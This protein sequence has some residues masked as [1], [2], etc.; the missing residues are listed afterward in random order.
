MR[1]GVVLLWLSL[2]VLPLGCN[3]E[4]R[5][6][7][8]ESL[9]IEPKSAATGEFLQDYVLELVWWTTSFASHG[10]DAEMWKQA[11]PR[12]SIF[13]T[14]VH[15]GPAEMYVPQYIYYEACEPLGGGKQ[16]VLVRGRWLEW[17]VYAA[18]YERGRG[19][20]T[21]PLD[22]QVKKHVAETLELRRWE[23]NSTKEF[24]DFWSQVTSEFVFPRI[25]EAWKDA[26]RKS[27]FRPAIKRICGWCVA[28]YKAA[29]EADS[30]LKQDETA[31]E[32]IARVR[33]LLER[34]N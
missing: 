5:Q 29:V 7:G 13:Y 32:H 10:Q 34:L 26:A 17:R 16:S 1:G 33:E 27:E 14:G 11:D 8:G 19:S 4:Q 21:G 2:V 28:R 15:S 18:G 3:C 25:L 12:P 6:S 20:A 23:D 22:K 30:E 24:A 31:A 9:R